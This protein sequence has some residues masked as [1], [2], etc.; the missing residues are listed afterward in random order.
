MLPA[1]NPESDSQHKLRQEINSRSCKDHTVKP[2]KDSTMSRD[3]FP[4]ILNLMISFDCRSSQISIH[5][6][7]CSDCT[8]DRIGD[9]RIFCLQMTAYDCRIDGSQKCRTA[10]PAAG[11]E[12]GIH[13]V[14][15]SYTANPSAAPRTG[16][17]TFKA[18][19]YTETFTLTQKQ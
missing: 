1:A 16:T 4:V 5:G 3:Q 18:G 2:V 10:N 6:D 8:D 19:T 7:Q 14:K 12:K 13:V 15:L 9:H 17:V 11:G